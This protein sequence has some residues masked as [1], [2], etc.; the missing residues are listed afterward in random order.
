MIEALLMMI[1]YELHDEIGLMKSLGKMIDWGYLSAMYNLNTNGSEMIMFVIGLGVFWG[2]LEQGLW[3][4]LDIFD[5]V[6]RTA[7]PGLSKKG[8]VGSLLHT[9]QS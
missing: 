4:E 3:A 6:H 2:S 5:D 9:A 8:K 1:K 7:L